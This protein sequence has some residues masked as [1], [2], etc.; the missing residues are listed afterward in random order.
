MPMNKPSKVGISI[1]VGAVLIIFISAG[2]IALYAS[3]QTHEANAVLSRFG[4]SLVQH[5]YS[6]AYQLTSSGFQSKT[7]ESTFREQQATLA[8]EYGNL[9]S[10]SV[11][12]YVSRRRDD[13]YSASF[14]TDFA[15][16]K[17]IRPFHIEMTKQEG[18]WKIDACSEE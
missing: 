7:S 16:D 11:T 13:G 8:G 18:V 10:V 15:F 1:V 5:K 14:E 6:A 4:E 9:Q 17:N 2:L 12:S 3:I